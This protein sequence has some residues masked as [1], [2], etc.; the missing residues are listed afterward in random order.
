[1]TSK[2]VL[3]DVDGVIFKHPPTMHKVYS[4][5]Q[6][7]VAKAANVPLVHGSVINESLYRNFGHTYIGL[8]RV[9]NTK[10]ELQDFNNFVYTEDIVKSVYQSTYNIDT[11]QHLIELQAFLDACS[12]T[13]THVYMFSNAPSQWCKEIRTAF[14]LSKWI[15]HENVITCDHDIF[16]NTKQSLK[17]QPAVYKM[18]HEYLRHGY[19]RE[20][21]IMYVDDSFMNLIPV[22]DAPSWKPVLF[23]EKHVSLCSSKVIQAASFKQL[24]PYI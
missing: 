10:K 11:L 7:Y 14:N 1:M 20:L 21:Q 5:I 23:D 24:T 18:L 17:P 8:Q 3:L 16:Q 22:I 4:R 9:Y 2:I 13:N 6:Q 15:P 12:K 19:D